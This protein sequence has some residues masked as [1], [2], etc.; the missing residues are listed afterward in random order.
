LKI[1]QI[2]TLQVGEFPNLVYVLI[3]TDEGVSG[4]GETFLG[5]EAVASYIH[6]TAAPILLGQDPLRIEQ[7]AHRLRG[8]LG[9]NGTGAETR[10]NSAIDIALWDLFGKAV[11]QP[12]HQL[13][14]G[15]VR[16]RIRIY[17]T[18]AGYEYGRGPYHEP[19]DGGVPPGE[20]VGPYEDLHAFLHRPEE[21]AESL[22]EQGIT[23]MKI[24]PFDLIAQETGGR[25]ITGPQLT[26]GL[27]PL[28]RIRE[29]VGNRI[30]V[31][32]EFHGLWNR[33]SAMRICAAA[34]EFDP[35]W[36]EDL[37]RADDYD[38]L[39]RIAASTS[40]PLTLSENLAGLTTF[41]NLM[42]SGAVG[43]AMVDVGWVG[44]ITESRRIAALAAAHQL[45][46]APHDCTG[47]VV[48]TASTHLSLH[49]PNAL[50]QETVRAYY[51]T[52]YQDLVTAL[53]SISDGEITPPEGPGLGLEINPD[54][55]TRADAH[56]RTSTA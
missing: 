49:L 31:M 30:D 5:A 33:P 39:Q 12:I 23:A 20:G 44:G 21:L 25:F 1:D 2:R 52:W 10:G 13:L 36:F 53:P 28:R 37:M 27:E 3:D 55:L 22:L 19:R 35:Y 11:G 43:V 46:V 51:T 16:D 14:G 18:C 4:L 6:E 50:I 15:R 56:V 8:P 9:F 54:L 42:N 26:A 17:N 45:P 40:T 48:L 41:R 7:H 34:D 47:P 38:G 24:W 29:A 32:L